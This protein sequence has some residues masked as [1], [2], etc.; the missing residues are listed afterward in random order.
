M[1]DS[2][3]NSFSLFVLQKNHGCEKSFFMFHSEKIFY[4]S[5]KYSDEMLWDVASQSI[6]SSILLTV[7]IE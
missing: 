7:S 4:V 2:S 3:N 1:N 6:N 5:H